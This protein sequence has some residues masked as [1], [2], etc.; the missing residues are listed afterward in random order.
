MATRCRRWSSAMRNG[1]RGTEVTFLPSP[2]TFTHIEFDFATLEHRLREL[3]F[4]N[5]GVKIVLSDCATREKREEMLLRRRRRGLRALSRPRKKPLIPSPIVV[6]AEHERHRRRGGAV[7]ERQLPREHAVL[8]QQHPAARRRHAPR[9]LPRRADAP[10]H[11]YADAAWRQERKDRADRRRLPRGPDLRAVGQGARPE[12]L[13]AD[14]GQAR[15]LRGAPGGRGRGRTRR[16][17]PGSR[18]IRGSRAHRRQGAS[19][20][21]PPARRRARRA[22]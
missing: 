9:R 14:Q 4:L 15:L 18:S 12:I 6:R 19:R 17:R 13:L 3:A 2:E 22:S 20:P 8:H 5:S 1:K 10:G 16:S 11:G 21:P 7:V